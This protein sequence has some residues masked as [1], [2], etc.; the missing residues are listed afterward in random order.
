MIKKKDQEG[1][2]M[3]MTEHALQL[4]RDLSDAPGASGFED[5]VVRTARPYAETIG[6]AKVEP[7]YLPQGK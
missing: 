6:Q 3:N 4:L 7:L 1:F 2:P 5:E